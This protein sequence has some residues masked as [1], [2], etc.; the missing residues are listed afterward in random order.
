[1]SKSTASAKKVVVLNICARVRLSL[2]R[3]REYAER[4]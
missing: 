1:M 3:E 2:L 4:T